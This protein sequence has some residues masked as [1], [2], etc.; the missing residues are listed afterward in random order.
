MQLSIRTIAFFTSFL[1]SGNSVLAGVTR[2]ENHCG[3][4]VCATFQNI[5]NDNI[6]VSLKC[7][8]NAGL[9][10]PFQLEGT[11]K[12]GVAWYDLSAVDGDP[13]LNQRRVGYWPNTNCQIVCNPGDKGCE[14]PYQQTCPNPTDM[15]LA[16]C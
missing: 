2:I 4:T 5:N 12:G 10:Q 6:G 9:S 11:I 3:F 7:A 15:V 13:F 1:A 14:W 8:N 16:L